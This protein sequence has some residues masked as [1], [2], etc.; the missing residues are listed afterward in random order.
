MDEGKPQHVERVLVH[1]LRVPLAGYG[2]A[3]HRQVAAAQLVAV[4]LPE[5]MDIVRNIDVLFRELVGEPVEERVFVHRLQARMRVEHL[6]QQ[7]RAGARKTD[8]EHR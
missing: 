8:D 1:D 3:Y 7:G 2:A 5:A 4:A 6:F